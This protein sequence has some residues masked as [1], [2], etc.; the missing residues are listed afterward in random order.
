[1]IGCYGSLGAVFRAYAAGAIRDGIADPKVDAA[2]A[3]LSGGFSEALKIDA[4]SSTI[5]LR[6]SAIASY[7]QFGMAALD[8]E[9]F[10]VLFMDGR[11]K[12]LG[13][14]TMWTG[15]IDRVQIHVR[16]VLYETLSL[17]ATAIIVAHNHVAS[18]AQPSQQ[19][20]WVT[21]KLLAACRPF[22]VVLHDHLIVTHAEIHSMRASG[23]ID[24]LIAS[25]SDAADFGCVL[26]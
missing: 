19:D 18:D 25:Q 21:A 9:A 17:G 7:L 23:V 10:R 1:L 3:K 2:L 14:Q 5:E 22:D 12:L 15:T 13:D 24:S 6:A 11:N 4:F 20:L 8:R 26:P 16:E